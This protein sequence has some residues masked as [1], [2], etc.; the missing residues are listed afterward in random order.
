MDRMRLFGDVAII[1]CN[2][3]NKCNLFEWILAIIA[4]GKI[5]VLDKNSELH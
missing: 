4:P 3:P 5:K 2:Q 1:S